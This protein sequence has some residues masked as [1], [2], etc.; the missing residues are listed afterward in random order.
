[1]A[2]GKAKTGRD[3]YDYLQEIRERAKSAYRAAQKAG[4][5]WVNSASSLEEGMAR[6]QKYTAWEEKYVNPIRAT[7]SR[8]GAAAGSSRGRGTIEAQVSPRIV[9]YAETGAR[10]PSGKA[11]GPEYLQEARGTTPKQQTSQYLNVAGSRA[12]ARSA[13]R[14]LSKD[15]A[16]LSTQINAAGKA[17]QRKFGLDIKKYYDAAGPAIRAKDL[18]GTGVVRAPRGRTVNEP[19]NPSVRINRGPVG[20]KYEPIKGKNTVPQA[21]RNAFKGLGGAGLGGLAGFGAGIDALWLQQRGDG[22]GGGG[23]RNQRKKK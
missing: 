1:M 6:A 17:A 23:D 10:V 7:R 4:V 2:R 19:V 18:K 9:R 11:P 5:S 16:A 3:E 22:G 8:L 15:V 20:S 21:F 14:A 12:A 13:G